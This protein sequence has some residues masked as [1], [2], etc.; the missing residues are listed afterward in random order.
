MKTVSDSFQEFMRRYEP[1]PWQKEIISRHHLYIRDILKGKLVIVED[2]LT[3]S[4][5]K[6]TQIKIPT[7]VDLFIDKGETRYKVDQNNF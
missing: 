1:T 4:Y 6:Q 3:G 7:D 5:I 2:F